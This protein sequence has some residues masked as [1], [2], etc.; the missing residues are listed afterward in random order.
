MRPLKDVK[1]V[2]MYD[3][4]AL[5]LIITDSGV[6]KD[7]EIQLPNLE[8]NYIESANTMLCKCFAGKTLSQILST[9]VD[10]DSEL[11]AFKQ[12]FENV[13]DLLSEY[14]KSRENELYVEGADKIFDY[15]ESK[16][17]DN[18]KNFMTI[19]GK[20]EKLKELM[21]DDGNIEFSVKIGAEEGEG[22]ENMALVS[23]K[24][25]VKGKEVG[26]LGVI[27]PERMDYK[28]VLGVLKHLSK[29]IDKL[30]D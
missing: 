20:K 24:Y 3:G 9:Q 8:D 21:T 30:D 19:V 14:K 2:D 7:K 12:I 25:H 10:M 27:G 29:L 16:N 5:V 13:F 22:L 18:V 23:A 17:Y 11:K 26:Q 4:T 28:R 1:L 15:P 6:I